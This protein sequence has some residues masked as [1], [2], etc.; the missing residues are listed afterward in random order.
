MNSLKG[1]CA[2][3]TG[4]AHGIG[5][6]IVKRLASEAVTVLVLDLDEAS[7][8]STTVRVDLANAAALERAADRALS[9]LGHCEVL[10]NCAGISESTPLRRADLARYHHVLAVNLHAPIYLMKRC[11]R[12]MVRMGYGRIV[13]VTSI[14][15]SLSEPGY[16][17]YDVSKAGLEAATRSVAVELATGGV[18]VNAVAPGFVKTRM[19]VVDGADELESDWFKQSYVA[20]GRL[21]VGRAA[22][23]EEIAEAVAWLAS[24][25]NT[26]V[27]GQVVKVD[28]G[29]SATL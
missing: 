17:A 14:H 7:G 6:A 8:A 23:P 5:A 12:E 22:M 3:V 29:L 15:G 9:V 1:S 27:V 4:G 20:G 19:S 2:V 18:V 11:A 10:I 25:A 26:Y 28:G 13:N 24:P 21:P 16:L